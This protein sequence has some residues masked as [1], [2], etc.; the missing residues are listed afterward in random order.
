LFIRSTHDLRSRGGRVASTEKIGRCSEARLAR[1]RKDSDFVPCGQSNFV[2]RRLTLWLRC[3]IGARRV[4]APSRPAHRDAAKTIPLRRNFAGSFLPGLQALRLLA[5]SKNFELIFLVDVSICRSFLR[6][7]NSESIAE[8]ARFLKHS[9]RP[10]NRYKP[11]IF[12]YL[13]LFRTRFTDFAGNSIGAWNPILFFGRKGVWTPLPEGFENRLKSRVLALFEPEPEV[14]GKSLAICA[15]P[16]D[17][18][19]QWW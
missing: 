1:Y 17:S 19:L 13:R 15:E 10:T 12:Y 4:P 11:R 8:M 16:P 2:D 18:N 3:K 7:D 14:F 5:Q 6:I 9:R